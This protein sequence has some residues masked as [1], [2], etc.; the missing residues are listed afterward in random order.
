MA[1]E[2]TGR[3][4]IV[5]DELLVAMMMECHF[6]DLGYEV[7]GPALR[8]DHGLELARSADL[9]FAVLD[10]NLGATLSFPIAD[11]LARR[12]IP[13]CFATAHGRLCPDHRHAGVPM[14]DKPFMLDDLEDAMRSATRIA[15]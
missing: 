13:F 8:L 15:A 7:I 1:A 9:D 10:V 3:V 4:L 2:Q 11:A 6:Q 5:E 14:L 12:D